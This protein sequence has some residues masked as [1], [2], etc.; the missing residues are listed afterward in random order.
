MGKCIYCGKWA[1][2]FFKKHDECERKYLEQKRQKEEMENTLKIDLL[3]TISD[4]IKS[5]KNQLIG[6]NFSE[7]GVVP[8]LKKELLIYSEENTD[9]FLIKKNISYVGRSQGVSFRVAKGVR[10]RIGNS[11][12]E[13]IVNECEEYICSGNFLI[14]TVGVYFKGDFKSLKLRYNKLVSIDLDFNRLVL[15]KDTANSLPVIIGF[16]NKIIAKKIYEVILEII[17]NMN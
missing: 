12:G 15:I 9:L 2:L 17:E 1:G 6:L 3:N 13:R 16:K 10:F 11:Q 4:V 7:Y 14:S 8:F 5:D